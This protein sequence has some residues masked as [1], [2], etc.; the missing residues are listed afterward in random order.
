M[1]RMVRILCRLAVF[2][3]VLASFSTLW[4]D[5]VDEA[6]MPSDGMGQA[7][8]LV[9]AQ[10]K[11][12]E[13]RRESY[14]LVLRSQRKD[15]L[16]DELLAGRKS[17]RET[18]ACFCSLYDA[19]EAWRDP[20]CAKPGRADGESW[21]RLVIECAEIKISFEKSSGEGQAVRQRLEDE[22]DEYMRYHCTME[23]PD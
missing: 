9:E 23:L 11:G 15:Q 6:L 22:L 1:N 14:E 19:P 17:L 16:I 12:E 13:M 18:A 4:E 2:A 8:T 20:R 5:W 3:A 7:I 21:C 10:R